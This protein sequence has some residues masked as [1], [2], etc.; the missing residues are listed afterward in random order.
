MTP[1][2]NLE[3]REN[4]SLECSTGREERGRGGQGGGSIK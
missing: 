2:T 4:F 3:V 1:K